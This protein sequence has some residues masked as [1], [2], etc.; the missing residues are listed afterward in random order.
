MN[1][2]AS[3][4][5]KDYFEVNPTNKVETLA[6]IDAPTAEEFNKPLD[7]DVTDKTKH[8]LIQK[9]FEN[10]TKTLLRRRELDKLDEGGELYQDGGAIHP[11][12][13][14]WT[15]YEFLHTLLPKIYG[16][17]YVVSDEIAAKLTLEIAADETA[18]AEYATELMATEG[19]VSV[20]ELSSENYEAYSLKKKALENKKT[21][22]SNKELQAFVLTNPDL[23]PDHYVKEITASK[24][25]LIEQGLIMLDLSKDD[26]QWV[27]RYE[28]L[29][30]NVQ[31]KINHINQNTL[32]YKEH[33]SE[34]NFIAQIEALE[35]VK[36]VYAKI[37]AEGQNSIFIHPNSDFAIDAKKF[38]LEPIDF[39]LMDENAL[40]STT[41]SLQKGFINWLRKSD[42]VYPTDYQVTSGADAVIDFYVE[43]DQPDLGSQREN[44]NARQNA[45]I[46][47]ER[48]FQKFL[49]Q[50]LTDKCKERL[51]GIWNGLYNNLVIPDL[52]KIPVAL[53]LS[54]NFKDNVEFIPNP[55]QVQSV[56]FIKNCGSG[57]LAYGVGVGKTAASIMNVSYALDNSL[58]KKPIFVVPNA[59]YPKWLGEIGGYSETSY[60]V[61]YLEGKKK[62]TKVFLKQNKAINFAKKHD[63]D[64]VENTRQMKGLM[65]HITKIVGLFNL[66]YDIVRNELKVFTEDEQKQL[67]K[68][69]EFRAYMQAV[70]SDYNFED[71]EINQK[72]K[73]YYDDWEMEAINHAYAEYNYGNAS[74]IDE[75][76]RFIE[77][78]RKPR[79]KLLTKFQFFKKHN[80][81]PYLRELPYKIGK[82]REYPPNTIFVITYE[83]LKN[84]GTTKLMADERDSINSDTS[85]FGEVF[86][87]LS[88]GESITQ[89]RGW[90]SG[91][92]GE[93]PL[94]AAIETSMFG[95]VGK[96]K[97]YLDELNIDYA[98]FDESHFFKK[99]FTTSKG[100]TKEYA[101]YSDKTGLIG[102][103][104]KKYA[105][106]GKGGSASALGIAAY[107]LSRYIQYNNNNRNVVH[108]TAT[109]FTNQP[110]EVY[111]ML[112]LV[113]YERLKMAGYA[114]IEDFYDVFMKISFEIRFTASQQV[115]KEEVLS[116]YNNLPQMRSMIFFLMDYKN[117]SDANIKRPEK[118]MYPSLKSGR[119][120]ILPASPMQSEAFSQIKSYMAGDLNIDEICDVTEDIMDISSASE[121]ELIAIIVEGGT[122]AQKDK[123]LMAEIPL[124]ED[125][126]ATLEKDVQKIIDKEMK[127]EQ[128]FSEKAASTQDSALARVIRGLSM[129]R[130][131]TLSPY[132]FTCKKIGDQEPTYSKYVDNSPKLLYAIGCVKSTHDFER[133]NNLRPSGI[134]LYMNLGARPS[135]VFTNE[136]GVEVKKSWTKGGF[137]KI[138]E[139]FVHNL[140]YTEEQISI[141]SG[142]MSIA[143]KEKQKNRF[144]AG[145]S[146]VMLGSST[147]STGIDLQN[148]ASSL[149]QCAFDWNPT[150]NEQINGRIHRQGNR[151]SKIRIVYPMI[152]DSVDPVIF[153]ILQEKEKRIEEIWD[154]DGRTSAVSLAD[155]DPSEL[156]E[157]LITDPHS[158]TEY[159]MQKNIK[160]LEDEQIMY[161]N[162]LTVVRRASN[163]FDLFTQLQLP[164]KAALEVIDAFR[165]NKKR[166]EGLQVQ[167]DKM[168]EIMMQFMSEPETLAKE[169]AKINKDSYDHKND[170]DKRYEAKSFKD[171]DAEELFKTIT[172]WVYKSESWWNTSLDLN[173]DELNAFVNKEYPDWAQGIYTSKKELEAL[174][175]AAEKL[176]TE[177]DAIY[178]KINEH[179]SEI[180]SITRD[181][182]QWNKEAADKDERIIVLK[183]LINELELERINK[184]YA[185]KSANKNYRS[186]SGGVPMYF[187]SYRSGSATDRLTDWR[188][189]KQELDR[190]KDKLAI[191][192]IE[193]E[194]VFE[195]QQLIADNIARLSEEIQSIEAQRPEIFEKYKKEQEEKQKVAVS[196]EDRVLEFASVNSDYLTETLQT[197]EEDETPVAQAVVKRDAIPVEVMD[198]IDEVELSLTEIEAE[199]EGMKFL[200]SIAE[201]EQF[202]EIQ[203]EIEGLEI[204]KS[205]I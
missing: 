10:R 60:S 28:Y 122:D 30:G 158:L 58:A 105:A 15:P 23:N 73:S 59:T 177:S 13:E 71:I 45:Q 123:W 126:R 198:V 88:Q 46:D 164:V 131:V 125:E 204:L 27:Y 184:S 190:L 19:A 145:Q 42:E 70:P 102:R 142:G 104:P 180:E 194:N 117:G 139:Y 93:Q 199:I 157:K 181:V 55:T 66:N 48:L 114:H 92:A 120:T 77:M 166:E 138:K 81:D 121:Q 129:M 113:N 167:K 3:K 140:G 63:V 182:H 89:V 151:F 106:L 87:E 176:D 5:N 178:E 67:E 169:V 165:K 172:N 108:L 179:R 69:D 34:S 152:E 79:Y 41:Q 168:Q 189:A 38:S 156:K 175:Q 146:I 52:Y 33:L 136:E 6:Q 193:V 39:K 144:L 149:F 98:V 72:I 95:G 107:I 186:L 115:K 31:E 84:L 56:Q 32:K 14:V 202:E 91:Q 147:I 37:T 25:D 26:N 22:V 76:N 99:I 148:N 135:V 64:V 43:G 65:P 112:A 203:N 16:K 137:E 35:S 188:R 57:L 80:V 119:D 36:N 162:R 161:R 29:S 44:D 201:E 68:A 130:Q 197:F 171:A 1:N 17:D 170:P 82:V 196:V 8:Q 24:D 132:L 90:V 154:K 150:D 21:F 153:Q 61:T 62:T 174:Q 109:P 47:G 74:R 191:M 103:E 20:F 173:I 86:K 100:R 185:L 127:S 159:W 11:N 143:E 205:L 49:V 54:K 124:K 51:E 53:T 160:E 50:G 2:K 141:V 94:A 128:V 183:S 85:F 110:I 134:V 75:N 4:I 187:H 155:F 40:Y 9:I 133:A 116:G 12:Q 163:E 101:E 111:S 78:G 83:G 18:L 97:I 118:I 192:G 7:E 195:A 200:L 96:P